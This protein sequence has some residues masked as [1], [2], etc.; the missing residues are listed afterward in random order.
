MVTRKPHARKSWNTHFR[1]SHGPDFTLFGNNNRMMFTLI[2][3]Q[4]G[5]GTTC[6]PQCPATVANDRP[7]CPARSASA[8][9]RKH[10]DRSSVKRRNATV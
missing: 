6:T 4:G 2:W 1:I 8:K 10:V 7:R 5:F 3:K 9:A